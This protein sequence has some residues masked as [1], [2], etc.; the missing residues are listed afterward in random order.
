MVLNFGTVLSDVSRIS[1]VT[2]TSY[3]RT[4]PLVPGQNR[5]DMG[6]DL[7]LAAVK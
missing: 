7:L 6:N 2:I 1:D 3:L 5:N 4:S